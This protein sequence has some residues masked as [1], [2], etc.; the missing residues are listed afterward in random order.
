MNRRRTIAVLGCLGLALVV[1]VGDGAGQE[2]KAD[3]QA[4]RTKDRTLQLPETP[5]NYARL[6]LPAHFRNRRADNTPRDNR[7][8]D[9]GATLGRV[10]FYDTRLSANNTVSCGSCHHQ[11]YGFSDPNRFSK[12]HAGKETDRNAMP[13]VNV[14]FYPGGR[15]FWD[16]RAATLEEQVLKPIQSPLEMGQT[17]P[18]VLAMIEKGPY[19]P[20]LF[21]KAFGDPK[22]SPER[23][24][25]ALAQFVRSLVSYQSKYDEGRAKVDSR[26]D[27]FPN[28]TREENRGKAVFNRRCATCHLQS[29]EAG[30]FMNGVRNNGLDGDVRTGDGGVGDLTLS[31]GQMGRFKSPTLR[32]VEVSGPYMHDGRLKTLEEVVDHYSKNIKPHPNLD[33]R[34]RG[35]VGRNDRP[36][37]SDRDKAALVAFLKTLTDEK[38]LT[39][40][41]FSDPFR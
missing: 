24:S 9:D 14:R 35:Q 19:Y 3:G 17:L 29:G 38:F 21:E 11:K 4:T 13:L 16:E 18:A 2:K 36:N 33:G 41:K 31:P 26:D 6:D 7:V 22:A 37:I 40:P 8:T 34:L 25:K 15:F 23:M 27:D 20:G 32:N 28:F 5:Y 30:F 10:L 39:D 1:P 12:G